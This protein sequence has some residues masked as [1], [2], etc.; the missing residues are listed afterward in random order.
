MEAH[1][2]AILTT[3]RT[4]GEEVA[5]EYRRVTGERLNPGTM[6]ST[7]R[8]LAEAKW[9]KTY[10]GEALDGRYHHYQITARGRAALQRSIEF[11][12]TMAKRLSDLQATAAN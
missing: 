2:L 12:K 9:S 5:D 7:I 1:I 4:G 3:D 11:H 10:Y 6:Y 8:R